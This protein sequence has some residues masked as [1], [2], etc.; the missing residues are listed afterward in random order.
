M[1]KFYHLI[2]LSLALFTATTGS[3]ADWPVL[4]Q[5]DAEHTCK[6]A[7]PVGGIGTGTVS[8]GGRGNFQDM[9]IMNRP[10]KGYNPG[11]G[12]FFLLYTDAGGKKDL[13]LLEGPIPI[14]LYE[15]GSGAVVSNHGLPRF[16][17][18]TFGAAYPFG[19]V[20]LRSPHVPLQV[21]VKSFNPLIPGDIDD[22]SIPMAVIDV[23]LA[24]T[25]GKEVRF[26]V[27]GNMQNF[28][29]EDGTNGKASKNKNT[30]LSKDGLNGILYTTEGVD[31]E[32]E[33]WGEMSLVSASQGEISYR[34]SWLPQRW[35]TSLLD[36]WDDLS[37]DGKLGNRV[38]DNTDKPMASLAVGDV[39]PA[40]ATKTV[41]F[42]FTW[43]FPNRKAWSSV[44]L[45]NYYTTKYSGAWD[46]AAKTLPDLDKLENKTIEFVNAFCKSSL[47]EAVK[48]AAL[49]NVSTLRT[50]TCFRLSDGN[51]FAWEGCNDKSGSCF[52]SCTHVWNYETATAFLFG[53]LARTMREV[54]FG[55]ATTDDGIMSFRVELPYENIPEFRKVAADGQMGCIMKLYREWQLSGDNDFLK[56]LYPKAKEALS[57]A[58]KK[59]GW[60]ANQDG[61]MEG[62]QHNTM[63]V[64]YYGPNPQMT[65]WYLGALRAM[66]EM[67]TYMKDREMAA[68]CKELFESGSKWTDENLFNGEYYIHKIEVP[69]KEDIP[70]EQLIGMG[71]TDYGNPDYQ[72][73]EGCLVD[74]LVGQ[75]MAHVCGLGYLVRK[76][77]VEQTLESIMKYNYRPDLSNHFNCMRSFAMGNE[78]ALLMA[79]Y[80]K[81]RPENPFPYFTEVMTGFEYTA[82]IGMLYEGQTENGLKCIRNIRARYDG[83]KRSPFDE[84]ECG[85]HY[86]RAMASWSA[87]LALSG[88]HYSGVSK[89]MTFTSDPGTYFW[90]NGYAW[91]TCKV[92][93]NKAA[94]NVLYGNL[95][96]SGFT[97]AGKGS[98]KLKNVQLHADG[99]DSRI[100]LEVK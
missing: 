76:D 72:L 53:G 97:L 32:S 19:Q 18:A 34:T 70:A 1:K 30:Y 81:T 2:I 45:K 54:E 95:D 39:I 38:D 9:E 89:T 11:G 93:G 43:Y 73:G 3:S 60:D 12:L 17:E 58:W 83:R 64:E 85:H 14:Y 5:Y 44:I 21:K 62:V 61:V 92:E 68:K 59:G 87:P 36:F 4:K 52:G 24:N 23:E 90:S 91:G 22:S 96:L 37:A 29:G 66:E 86:G 27:C 31:R 26:S 79:S 33:Q 7:L 28:T 74:Q 69:K 78:S 49:F 80:P 75:Y 94:L 42:L 77:H 50:Q 13:R 48:E 99:A 46:V 57:Y 16:E 15:G 65:I 6:I 51:F 84:A 98:V 25:S 10:A 88:F 47:P 56:T 8:F 67:S 41:R 63:D 100:V 71:T 82:A 40:G 35:G 55:K 20:S